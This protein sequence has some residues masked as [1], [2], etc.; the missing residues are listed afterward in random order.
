[1]RFPIPHDALGYRHGMTIVEMVVAIGIMSVLMLGTTLVLVTIWRTQGYAVR[2]GVASQKASQAVNRVTDMLRNAR[3]GDDGTFP[4][5]AVGS[6]AVTFYGDAD[7]DAD[8]ELIRIYR[9]AG[10]IVQGV[11]EPSATVPVTYPTAS[12]TLSTVMTGVLD[13]PDG[14]AFL[15]YYDDANALLTNPAA[16]QVRMVRIAFAIGVEGADGTGLQSVPITSFASLRN[17]REW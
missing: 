12:E 16:S 13:A 5:V 3:Q 10:S 1:M 2:T 4:V 9:D 15:T 6:T 14:V 11:T 7:G 8:T 17:L